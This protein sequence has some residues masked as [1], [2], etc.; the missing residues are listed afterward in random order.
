MKPC[1]PSEAASPSVNGLKFKIKRTS[2]DDGRPSNNHVATPIL[3]SS[4][5]AAPYS[6]DNR[7]VSKMKKWSF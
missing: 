2:T 4:A 7:C 1:L 3:P 6:P 5:A